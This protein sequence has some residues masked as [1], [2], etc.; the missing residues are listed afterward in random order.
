MALKRT[1]LPLYLQLSGMLEKDIDSGKYPPGSQLPT[2]AEFSAAHGVSLITARAAMRVLMDKRRIVRYP[3]KGTFVRADDG[4]RAEWGLGSIA[5]LVLTGLTSKLVLLERRLKAPP[6]WVAQKLSLPPNAELYVLRTARESRGER[7]TVTDIY[8]PLQIGQLITEADCRDHAAQSK[9]MIALV[10]E[11]TGIRP[12]EIHQWLSAGLADEQTA[13][14]LGIQP[15][16]PSLTVERDY[17]SSD[18]QL[19][20]TAL[21]KYRVDHHRYQMNFSRFQLGDEASEA[22]PLSGRQPLPT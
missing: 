21:S 10:Q 2:D 12:H 6:A 20:Q 11:K 16:Q 22:D 13:R 15:G 3:G 14:D 9:L 7:F 17:Y 18:G 19:M 4:I 1:G 5:E 8:H